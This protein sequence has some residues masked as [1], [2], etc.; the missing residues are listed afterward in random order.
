MAVFYIGL[1][2]LGYCF[3]HIASKLEV[4]IDSKTVNNTV[5][6]TVNTAAAAATATTTT[7]TTNN[8]NVEEQGTTAHT[9]CK[10]S[11]LANIVTPELVKK[12]RENKYQNVVK[13]NDVMETI[14]WLSILSFFGSPHGIFCLY[15]IL[16]ICSGFSNLEV[17]KGQSAL[18]TFVSS[19][20]ITAGGSIVTFIPFA[21]LWDKFYLEHP[22]KGGHG[23]RSEHGEPWMWFHSGV[24]RRAKRARQCRL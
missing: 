11:P 21:R 15:G 1:L 13:K 6:T 10:E 7:S 8:N 23:E 14:L 5:A 9:E 4:P 20:L 22:G 19:S 2:T 16:H 17:I 24:A 12:S 18:F 3:Y